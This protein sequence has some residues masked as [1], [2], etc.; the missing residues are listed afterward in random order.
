MGAMKKYLMI[1]RNKA[2]DILNY[3]YGPDR[4]FNKSLV[5]N[6]YCCLYTSEKIKTNSEIIG[7]SLSL[8][9]N[10]R[11]AEL[12]GVEPIEGNAYFYNI[13]TPLNSIDDFSRFTKDEKEL[14]KDCTVMEYNSKWDKLGYYEYYEQ[15]PPKIV[16]TGKENNTYKTTLTDSIDWFALAFAVPFAFLLSPIFIYLGIE[17]LINWIKDK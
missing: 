2:S 17:E 8:E 11:V 14:T 3:V 5:P 15:D 9:D 12:F 13:Y 1:Y 16:R 4:K 7:G 10:Y 6:N